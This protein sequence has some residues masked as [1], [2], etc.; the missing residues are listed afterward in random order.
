[1]FGT[2]LGVGGT[3]VETNP[4]PTT[5]A[6]FVTGPG[7]K[8][9]PIRTT[10]STSNPEEARR[11]ILMVAAAFGIPETFFGDASVGTVATA[12]SL[13]R[14][15][16]LKF[17][18]RQ[19]HWRGYLQRICRYVLRR[20]GVAPRGKLREAVSSGQTAESY[21]ITVKFPAIL[22]HDV[23]AMVTAIQTAATL[24]GFT[25]ADTIDK[26]TLSFLLLSELGVDN[27]TEK[28]DAMYPPATFDPEVDMTP[29]PTPPPAP[30]PGAFPPAAPA[31]AKPDDE[32]QQKEREALVRML[33]KIR[34]ACEIIVKE[35]AA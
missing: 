9:T 23:A 28:V 35:R 5:G 12:Q 19:E 11:L 2:T 7:N 17:L 29:P 18:E 1:V 3:Q 21:D 27:P 33:A 32:K 8:L 26:R 14:P 6:A 30:H 16:E 13:D 4:V 15:T 20:S 25:E 34:E 10:G 24:G 31:P 22:E